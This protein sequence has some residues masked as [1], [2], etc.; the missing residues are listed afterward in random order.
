MVLVRGVA[1]IC[2]F[3]NTQAGNKKGTSV[4]LSPWF[5]TKERVVGLGEHLIFLGA[6]ELP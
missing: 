3:V 4:G 6:V 1:C 2:A 5:I